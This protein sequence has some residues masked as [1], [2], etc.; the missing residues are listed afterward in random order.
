MTGP[1]YRSLAVA[2]SSLLVLASAACGNGASASRSRA[3]AA[4]DSP[5]P[6]LG[7]AQAF[8]VLGGTT[9]TNTGPS[10]LGGDL[11]VSPGKAITGFPPGLAGGAVHAGDATAL[12]AQSDL[13]TAYLNLAG[14]PCSSDMT[15]K[16]LGGLTLV[17]GVYCFSSEAQ[18]TGTLVLDAQFVAGAAFVFQIGSKLTTASAASVRMVNG[19]SPCNVYWQVGSSATVGTASSFVGNILALTSISLSSGASLAGR[20]LARNGAVTLDDNQISSTDCAPVGGDGGVG[21]GGVGDGGAGD[22]GAGSGGVGDGG[23]GGGGVGDGG[24]GGGGAGGGGVAS[25][26]CCDGAKACGSLCAN[27]QTD[28]NNCGSCGKRCSASE[29]CIA[30]ACGPCTA[31]DTQCKDQC[32]NLNFDP[33]NCGACG[34]VCAASQSCM[35][36]SCGACDGTL[37]SNICVE[38]NTDPANCGACGNACAAGECCHAGSCGTRDA[39]DSSR[40]CK[41]K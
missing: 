36:G 5:A 41:Q 11:G 10:S 18:L 22:G 17:P 40:I 24:A 39:R 4:L 12:Q 1:L 14:Q 26:L 33:F 15:G 19:A 31:T 30:G 7:T 38:L 29:R 3:P 2:L 35:A 28:A 20:A 27:L 9:V 34:H 13:T 16:D 6:S 25:L 23:A 21:D 37:C 8:S 32:A